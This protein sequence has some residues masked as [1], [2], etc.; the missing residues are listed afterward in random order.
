ME[1]HT[2]ARVTRVERTDAGVRLEIQQGSLVGHLEAEELLVATGRVPNIETLGLAAAGV[3]ADGRG[4]IA[5]DAFMRTSNPR[6]FAAGDVTGGPGFVYVAALQG[7]VAAQAALAGST[8]EAP[9][10]ADLGTVPRVTFTDPQV[11]AVGLTEAEARAAGRTPQDTSLPVEYLPRAAVSYRRQG[12][13]K[14]VAEAGTDRLLGAHV[15]APNA[16]DIISEA[17]L[18]VRFGLTTRDLVSTLHPYLTWGEALKLAA[19]TFTQDVAKLS[20]CA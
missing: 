3:H 5:V 9:I 16:G 17:V 1:L 12:A 20:C 2:G 14:L 7:G 15:V 10:P 19:Q 11:A 4:Y 6:V 18:A 8:G 13:I